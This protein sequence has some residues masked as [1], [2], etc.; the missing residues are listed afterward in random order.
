[1]R[2]LLHSIDALYTCDDAHLAL[3][4]AY[5]VVDGER[6]AEIGAGTPPAGDFD[7]TIDLS[8][9]LVVPG[10]VN[11]HHHFFQTLTRAIPATQRGHLI[12]WLRLMYPVWAGMTPDHLAAATRATAAELLLTGATTSVDH[13][14]LI[15]RCD[16]AFVDAEVAA[17]REAG[18][19]LHLVRGSITALEADL[20]RELT[21]L[22]GPRAGGILDDP[23]AVLADMKGTIARHHASGWGNRVSVGL[24]PT[25]TTFDDLDFMA[26]VARS[27]GESGASLHTHFHPRP[28]ERALT[29]ARFG[30]T[31]SEILVEAGWMT[32]RTFFA[33]STR[34]D[35]DDMRRIADAGAAVVHCPRMVMRLGAR[36]SEVHAMRDAG[37]RVAVGVDGGASNDAGSMIGEMRLAL[38]LH[39]VAGG[40]GT[41]PVES[42]LDPYDVLLMA[43]REG[44]AI[45]GRDD[46]GRISVGACADITAFGV[47]RVDLAGGRTD[48]LSGLLLAGDGNRAALTMVGGDILVRDGRLVGDDEETIGNAVDRATAE[49][50]ARASDLTGVDYSAFAM[51]KG[52][53]PAPS[54]PARSR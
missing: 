12:D 15:P 3:S 14:Y 28:D 32:P 52:R 40:Q 30:K 25:T 22:L 46:I 38:L 53:P 1:M 31:P 51:R 35:A 8:G 23:A 19:R 42:W 49:L 13:A 48:L 39:R 21:A 7:D 9:T 17:A 33:H 44:A 47:G 18:L 26:A 29:A 10:L 43:T 54:I 20:E 4:D 2:R 45:L 36:V 24:G 50:T 11:M 6:I 5:I 41:V 37:V 27:A 34:L 16:P